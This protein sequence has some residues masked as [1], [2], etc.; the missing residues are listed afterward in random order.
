MN[1]QRLRHHLRSVIRRYLRSW[2]P[3]KHGRVGGYNGEDGEVEDAD[4]EAEDG[5]VEA[6]TRT[7]R[8][9]TGGNSFV[10]GPST[11]CKQSYAAA[12]ISGT[13]NSFTGIPGSADDGPSTACKQSYAAAGISGTGN[14]FI[15]GPSTA[16]KQS[17]AA[18]G[19]SGYS[20]G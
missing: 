19:I 18:A 3:S 7:W 10:Y 16:Y 2:I 6:R 1:L 11:T 20:P 15:Y 8:H 9:T 5:D 14:S 4:V 17:D 12:G 13:G